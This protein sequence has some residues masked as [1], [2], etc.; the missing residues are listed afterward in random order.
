[1]LGEVMHATK[2]P[3]RSGF[4]L[5]ELMVVLAVVGVV[6]VLVPPTFRKIIDMQRLRGLSDQFVTD[7]Q[8]VRSEAASRQ[9]VAG[10]SFKSSTGGRTCYVVHTCGSTPADTCFCDC[11]AAVGSRCVAPMTEIRTVQLDTAS[12]VR[13]VPARVTGANRTANRIM[14][15]PA[16]GG[17]SYYFLVG[18]VAVIPPPSGEFWA[19]S[20]STAPGFAASLRTEIS[21]TGRPR[22][23]SPAGDVIGVPTC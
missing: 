14:F 4:T 9:E 5:I 7:V 2:I 20:S 1:M 11:S 8:F 3:L 6:L 23:C 21:S 12:T 15:D 22:V 13:L 10:I 19:L 16:T 17:M 18:V